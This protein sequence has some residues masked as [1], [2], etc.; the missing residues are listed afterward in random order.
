MTVVP[1]NWGVTTGPPVEWLRVAVT[2]NHATPE[3]LA[4]GPAVN[5]TVTGTAT[6]Q[7]R[8]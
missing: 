4:N 1:G 7:R 2:E 5:D 3:A 8:R 6:P